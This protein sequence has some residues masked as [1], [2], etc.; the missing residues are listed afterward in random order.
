VGELQ[1]ALG[2]AAAGQGITVVPEGLLSMKRDD[3]TYR[4]IA[5]RQAISPVILSVRLVDRA[6]ELQNM[7]AKANSAVFRERGM[8]GLAGSE[9]WTVSMLGTQYVCECCRLSMVKSKR[10]FWPK[11]SRYEQGEAAPG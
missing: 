9:T 6:E 4:P 3:I 5:D 1:I 7:L 2:L 8:R 11:P 10:L